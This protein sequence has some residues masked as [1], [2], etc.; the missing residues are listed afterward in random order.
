M[1]GTFDIMKWYVESRKVCA[2]LQTY[3][4]ITALHCAIATHQN[5]KVKYLLSHYRVD[6][7]DRQMGALPMLPVATP[8]AFAAYS[9]NV[10]AF[11]MMVA[12]GAD[13]TWYSPACEQ[14]WSRSQG[15]LVSPLVAAIIGN[16]EDK[17]GVVQTLVQCGC[18]PNAPGAGVRKSY[19]SVVA[20]PLYMAIKLKRPNAVSELLRCGADPTRLN[21]GFAYHHANMTWFAVTLLTGPDPLPKATLCQIVACGGSWDCTHDDVW[22]WRAVHNDTPECTMVKRIEQLWSPQA[23]RL[24]R[25][26]LCTALGAPEMALPRFQRERLP[27]EVLLKRYSTRFLLRHLFWS[28]VRHRD[29]TRAIQEMYKTFAL[30]CCRVAAMKTAP[31][32]PVDMVTYIARFFSRFFEPAAD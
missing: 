21:G 27:Q 31:E 2:R 23:S 17:P 26:V 14:L 19:Q 16:T 15:R 3:Q 18:D 12:A 1:P 24:H 13:P 30:A 28:P 5:D 11:R 10:E 8:L 32:L 7:L 6:E 22:V 20:L 4:A 9:G 25:D 29:C